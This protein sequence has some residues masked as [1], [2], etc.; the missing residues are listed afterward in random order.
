[1]VEEHFSNP[2][3]LVSVKVNGLPT[4][5]FEII[6]TDCQSLTSFFGCFLKKLLTRVCSALLLCAHNTGQTASEV[7]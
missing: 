2:L 7:E 4:I 6:L 3:R 5:L 1:V